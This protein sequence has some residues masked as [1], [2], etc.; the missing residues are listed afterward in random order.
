[1][2]GN[3]ASYVAPV[4]G[5]GIRAARWLVPGLLLA[6]MLLGLVGHAFAD[7]SYK[8][9]PGD[10]LS[11]IAVRY[12]TTVEAIVAA[13]N[14]PSRTIYAGQ[15]LVIPSAGSTGGSQSAA[16]SNGSTYVVQPGD[17]LTVLAQR[18]GTTREALAAANG[19]SPSALLYVGQVLNIPG[20]QQQQPPPPPA[21]PTAT[22][23]PPT[24]TPSVPTA[25]PDPSKPQ[26]HTVQP[27]ENLSL[28]AS[29]YSTTVE[30]LMLANNIANPS[31]L[32][33]G[34]VLTI[35]KPGQSSTGNS[36]SRSRAAPAEPKPPMGEFGPKWVEVSIS[37]QA[38]TAYEGN[39]PVYSTKISSG[40][41][42]YPTVEGTFRVYAKYAQTR[43]RGGE[44]AD[45]YDIPD[46][47]YTMYFY[48][49]YALHG[50]YWHNNFGTPQS[51]G[52]VNL[53]PQDAKWLYDWA[54]I[55]TMVVTRK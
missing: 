40:R 22:R 2:H 25:T 16:P 12:G 42:R 26:T 21:Q 28:I 41:S 24:A 14:L 39:T 27:G 33:S 6:V 19:I 17:N 3:I 46:V 18:F 37:T 1:M 11:G 31:L 8:V 20:G 52:C 50:A 15:T 49:D 5:R 38:L 10:T 9:Q 36:A 32:Y 23:V 35:V 53:S 4:R 7:T 43:M 34:Q 51:H 47:P 55:G 48:S 45:R 29:R 44:G 54:P 13:N 30:A